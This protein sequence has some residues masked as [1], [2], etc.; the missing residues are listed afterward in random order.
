MCRISSSVAK[1]GLVRH[2]GIEPYIAFGELSN[3]PSQ[4]CEQ[5]K[6]AFERAG[7]RAEIP[8]DIQA[9][10]WEKFVFIAAVSGLGAAAGAPLGVLRSVPETRNL[11][12]QAME[13]TAAVGRAKGVN[14]SSAMVPRTLAHIDGMLAGVTASMQRDIAEGCPSELDSQNGAVVRM[15][16]QAGIPTPVHN[17]LYGILL[18]K[19]MKARGALEY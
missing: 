1:P 6:A 11:L 19:E 10:M 12:V 17:F 5:L 9:A 16:N 7:V 8:A 15:G 13:E 18:P 3:S 4:R 2:T 14:L